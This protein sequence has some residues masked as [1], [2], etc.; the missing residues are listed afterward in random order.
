MRPLLLLLLT[1]SPAFAQDSTIAF[2]HRYILKMA[3]SAL[4]DL[5]ATVQLGLEFPIGPRTAFQTEFGYGNNKLPIFGSDYRNME[6][7]EVWRF[8]NEFRKYNGHYRTNSSRNINI[9]ATPP[10]G[11]YWAVDLL[12]KQ[13]NVIDRGRQQRL[14]LASH[15]KIGRQFAPF[16]LDKK[17]GDLL[18]DVYLGVG[19]RYF[20]VIRQIPQA[21]Y[22]DVF[23]G[24]FDRFVPGNYILPSL[25]AGL[26][27]GFGL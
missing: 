2:N 25:T 6:A 12:T 17:P 4:I 27:M 9:K 21:R 18:F 1:V 26:K 23:P 8:R 20:N 16:R 7:G 19:V 15:I 11:N 14:V 10:L 13:I 22:S 24:V 3:L 5:D